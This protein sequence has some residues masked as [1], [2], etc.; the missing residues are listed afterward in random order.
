[1]G[2]G[3]AIFDA[4]NDGF[5]DLYF[6]QSG[7][8]AN[9]LD[10]HHD[11]LYLNDGA[12]NFNRSENSGLPTNYGMGVATGDYDNDGDIDL[13]VSN[14]GPDSL[15]ENRGQA[16]FHNVSAAAGITATGFSTSASFAD[17][18][19]DGDL[20]LFVTRYLRWSKQTELQCFDLGSGIRNYCDPSN[21][22]RPTTDILYRNN[23]DGTFDDVSITSGI[24]AS[25]GNGLGVVVA[26]FNTDGLPD[27]AVANDRTINHLWINLGELKFVD[28]AIEQG[29]A[30]DEAGIAKAGMGIVA[31][32][33]DSDA[34]PDLL[35]VNIEGETDSLFRNESGFFSTQTVRFGLANHS[36]TSTRFGIATADFDND[37]SL[38]L[39]I[40]NGKVTFSLESEVSDVYAERN[41]VLRGQ[42]GSKFA[43]VAGAFESDEKLIH[44]SRGLATGD[45]DQDGRLDVVI[46]NRNSRPYVLM[47]QTQSGH[48][49]LQI[50]LFN[51]QS[52]V[53]TGA[54]VT[55]SDS[56]PKRG[57]R[58]HSD[59][60]YLSASSP[61][62]HWGLGSVTNVSS[63][64]VKWVDGSCESFSQLE[65]NARW[66]LRQGGGRSHPC[67]D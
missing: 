61:V 3:L 25:S 49:W 20:D 23:G 16:K 52:R 57:Q 64:D 8:L 53:A 4:D 45:L 12:G 14:V 66:T 18:D 6:V 21:Y 63:L 30:M 39:A 2:S 10:T 24:A 60:S 34:D 38:D 47:N 26:D 5:E 51:Q 50:R 32:D 17:F 36:R 13:F 22:N 54:L 44:T 15:L 19:L 55:S 42:E 1:M 41:L 56:L 29:V 46:T 27:I 33:F 11:E 59:G 67:R 43:L 58:V 31:V 7:S 40:A 37:G 35:V 62:L 9:P 48:N 65:V 28:Q